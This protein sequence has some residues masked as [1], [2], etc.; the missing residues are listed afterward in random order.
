MSSRV[1]LLARACRD[2]AGA[3]AA[4]FALVLPALAMLIAGLISVSQLAAA[5]SGMHFAVEEAARC[6][7]VNAV[8]C[9][10]NSATI[11]FA[12]ARYAGPSSP[13]FAST[14]AGCGHTVT[15]TATFHL[16][17]LVKSF[18]IPLSAAACYPGL[19]PAA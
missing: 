5:V 15:A 19:A 7:A 2:T 6:S 11:S 10:T 1:R 8:L 18:D 14:A 16:Q 13:V 3:T 9:G 4:E 17:I 12:Q